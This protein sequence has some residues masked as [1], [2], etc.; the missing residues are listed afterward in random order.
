MKAA[1]APTIAASQIYRRVSS[2]A[3]KIDRAP[4]RHVREFCRDCS[5]R[6]YWSR[7][8][9]KINPNE[10]GIPVAPHSQKAGAKCVHGLGHQGY[11]FAVCPLGLGS[12]K[13]PP[14]HSG[15]DGFRKLENVE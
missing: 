5:G 6:H 4:R 13:K 2:A 8:I 15:Q 1:K 11:K 9:R 7:Y 12:K 14:P 10:T 3:I